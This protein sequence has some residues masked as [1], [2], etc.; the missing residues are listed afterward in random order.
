MSTE[1]LFNA[2]TDVIMEH[3]PEMYSDVDANA[4]VIATVC[5]LMGC[6]L[7]GLHWKTKEEYEYGLNAV[8]KR[9]RSTAE[10]A[11]KM[12]NGRDTIQ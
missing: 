11:F 2:M 1:E 4:R 9:V 3:E 5:D 12:K 8:M 6:M 7:A 10:I